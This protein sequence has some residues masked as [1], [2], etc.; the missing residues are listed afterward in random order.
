MYIV[1]F[2]QKLIKSFNKKYEVLDAPAVSRVGGRS[3]KLSDDRP[4]RTINKG[5]G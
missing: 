3:W 5:W 2:K 4:Q 1:F